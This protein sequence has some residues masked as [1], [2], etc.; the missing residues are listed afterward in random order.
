MAEL[1]DAYASGAYDR[2][3]I[4]VQIS[5]SAHKY[6]QKNYCSASAENPEKW[7]QR[8]LFGKGRLEI[9]PAGRIGGNRAQL[10]LF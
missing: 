3:V 10:R 6:D 2:K 7:S 9:R 4:G 5:S 1:A 8:T